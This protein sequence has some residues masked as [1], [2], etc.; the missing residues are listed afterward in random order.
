M[1]KILGPFP[2]ERPA[3]WLGERRHDM[4][5]LATGRLAEGNQS[6]RLEPF[7]RV[8]RRLDDAL[9]RD[10]RRGIEVEDEPARHRGPAWHAI[11]GMKLEPPRLGDR[12]DP[13]YRV[14]AQVRLCL[15]ANL[16]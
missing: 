8:L 10:A 4:Q 6:E 1:G 7:A 13:F 2:V 15:A 11:P 12:D 14:D 3:P 9:E 5:A 16:D